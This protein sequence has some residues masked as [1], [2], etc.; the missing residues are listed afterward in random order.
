MSPRDDRSPHDP[1]SVDAIPRR[2]ALKIGI[3]V[4]GGAVLASAPLLSAC[5]RG[6][7]KHAAPTA[8]TISEADRSLMEQLADTILPT[9]ASSPGV[10][11]AGAG[12]FVGVLLADCYDSAQQGRVVAGLAG[13]REACQAQCGGGFTKLS[14]AQRETLVKALDADAVKAGPTHWFHLMRELSNRAF[15]SSE[16]GMTKA[17]RYVRIPGHFTGCLPLEKGQPAW[18]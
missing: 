1:D 14:P 18:G 15:F 3:A 16:A 13:V 2:D 12:P 4:A 5:A 9:T 7:T 6:D 10:I 17:L 11:A 8:V